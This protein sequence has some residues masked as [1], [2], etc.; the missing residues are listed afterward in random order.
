MYQLAVGRFG[1]QP[2]EFWEMTIAEWFALWEVHRPN[3]YAGNL[4][5]DVV[6]DLLDD[7]DLDDE[8]WW[9]KNGTAE[10]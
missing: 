3:N 9:E 7:L 1:V 10:R 6:D 5:H 2:G 8:E 4:T